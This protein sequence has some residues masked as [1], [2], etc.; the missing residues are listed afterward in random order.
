MNKYFIIISSLLL[1]IS[2]GQNIPPETFLFK[3]G[4]IGQAIV[5]YDQK[6]GVAEKLENGRRIYEIPL[7]GVYFTKSKL[8]NGIINQQYYFVDSNGNRHQIHKLH[9]SE[10]NKAN[11]N[12]KKLRKP[13]RDS[14]AIFNFGSVGSMTSGDNKTTYEYQ[15]LMVCAYKDLSSIKEIEFAYID[16]LA[17]YLK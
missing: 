3:Q 2:C 17:K 16:S 7:N 9:S 5:I 11:T 8:V 10:F 12:E 1:F 15:K 13:S 4:F 14:I 6:N